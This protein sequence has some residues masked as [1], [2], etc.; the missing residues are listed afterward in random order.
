[1]GGWWSYH[2]YFTS[3]QPG[4]WFI[5]FHTIDHTYTQ[6]SSFSYSC[7]LIYVY[8]YVCKPLLCFL[9][10][11]KG[12]YMSGMTLG[13]HQGLDWA[14]QMYQSMACFCLC[15]L[16]FVLRLTPICGRFKYGHRVALYSP[17][18]KIQ[19]YLLSIFTPSIPLQSMFTFRR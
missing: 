3:C 14:T 19:F 8:L 11:R 15:K 6:Y 4:F 16:S 1:M 12:R 2:Q 5:Y 18:S 7:V 10:V 17:K 9:L 13:H